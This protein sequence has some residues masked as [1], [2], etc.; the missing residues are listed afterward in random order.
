MEI[1]EM[2]E[3]ILHS[4]EDKERIILEYI[5]KTV[6]DDYMSTSDIK[7]RTIAKIDEVME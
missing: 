5:L 2:M 7:I 6:K 3:E 1:N 4:F